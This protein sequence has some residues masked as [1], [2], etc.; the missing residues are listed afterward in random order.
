MQLSPKLNLHVSCI[1]F[2]QMETFM[3]NII[4]KSVQILCLCIF[5]FF[6][7]FML[8]KNIR[9][10]KDQSIIGKSQIYYD[11]NPKYIKHDFITLEDQIL[12]TKLTW[13]CT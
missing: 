9:M 1:F 6:K 4:D 7:S 12:H 11:Q 3:F 5:C 13:R 2:F 8:K 10:T